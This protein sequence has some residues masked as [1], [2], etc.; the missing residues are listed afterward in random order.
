MSEDQE[1]PE[2]GADTGDLREN[3]PT[4]PGFADEPDRIFRSHFQH[5][6][7]LVDRAYEHVRGAYYLGFDVARDPARM[8]APFEQV[9]RDLESGWLNVRTAAGDWASVRDFAR[10]GFDRGRALG[11]IGETT[12][13]MDALSRPSFS[14]P[15]HDG[16]DPTAKE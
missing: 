6:N 8:G 7:K 13:P 15:L 1:I 14:D 3:D 4:T 10:E 12:E 5:A 2:T 16:L 9:E 11:F